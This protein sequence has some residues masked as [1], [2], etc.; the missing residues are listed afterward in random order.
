VEF[1]ESSTSVA[2]PKRG[3]RTIINAPFRELM[4]A[5]LA[6]DG[7]CSCAVLNRKLGFKPSEQRRIPHPHPHERIDAQFDALDRVPRSPSRACSVFVKPRAASS[8]AMRPLRAAIAMF[9]DFVML[10]RAQV[11]PGAWLAAIPCQCG[12]F[13][14]EIKQLRARCSSAEN[15]A[16]RRDMPARVVVLRRDGVADAAL[17]FDTKYERVQ[18]L[19]AR[20]PRVLSE[21]D[22]SS[23]HGNRRMEYRA[24]M[25]VVE[26]EYVGAEGVEQRG[27]QYIVSG[28]ATPHFAWAFAAA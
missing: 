4:Y 16:R 6:I 24:Q 3:H 1:A 23:P 15:A 7:R 11:V 22:H 5:D 13:R 10:P 25:R 19:R 18:Q 8:A 27:I 17:H 20:H 28:I 26:V 21:R 2:R 14:V 12:A 9:Y